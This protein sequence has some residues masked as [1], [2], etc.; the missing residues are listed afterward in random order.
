[1]SQTYGG[2]KMMPDGGSGRKHM[3]VIGA[4]KKNKMQQPFYKTEAEDTDNTSGY[5]GGNFGNDEKDVN[6]AQ[7]SMNNGM[8]GHVMPNMQQHAP[9]TIHQGGQGSRQQGQGGKFPGNNRTM[10]VGMPSMPMGMPSSPDR[11]GSGMRMGNVGPNVMQASRMNSV[12]GRQM[13]D[14][15]M[16]GPP[17]Q[18]T[19]AGSG[20]RQRLP[21]S[22][23]MP[24]KMP[25]Q[26]Q[27]QQQHIS[28]LPS[29]R[30]GTTNSLSS[31][32]LGGNSIV[33]DSSDFPALGSDQF[34]SLGSG[35]RGA[36]SGNGN[37]GGPSVS[38]SGNSTVGGATVAAAARGGGA[39]LGG[40][41][42]PGSGGPPGMYGGKKMPV[43][44]EGFNM[45]EDMFP[46]LPGA[47]SSGKSLGDSSRSPSQMMGGMPQMSG[48]GRGMDVLGGGS[49][50]IEQQQQPVSQ[51][52]PTGI[53]SRYNLIGLLDVVRLQKPDLKMMALGVDLTT[54]GLNLN[55]SDVLF[56]SFESPWADGPLRPQEP[57]FQLPPC[58]AVKTNM[59]HMAQRL[60]NV[61]DDTLFYVFYGMPGDVC[62]AVAAVILYERHWRYHQEQKIWITR[63]PG[64]EPTQKTSTFERGTYIYFD[65]GQWKKVSKDFILQY[66]QLEERKP[67]PPLPQS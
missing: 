63:A 34:P 7:M 45:S 39:A 29:Q 18:G 47:K 10:Q 4:V 50:A 23:D 20:S 16:V 48:D 67:M 65:I 55:S 42:G 41:V 32:T 2:R 3:T 35:G 19:S 36:G 22:Y 59:P 60:Q 52:V 27:Q 64:V 66:D 44:R 43:K 56:P 62:Q 11:M 53:E 51:Q 26:Q 8:Y 33:P 28:G 6:M 5:F 61:T 49:T 14:D 17:M 9:G 54:L 31:G 37:I 46:A 40:V 24:M 12:H 58:Y 57:Q 15:R 1:M 13:M 38:N 30:S 25:Q 21:Q